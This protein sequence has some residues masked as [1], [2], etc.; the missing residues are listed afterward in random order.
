MI[1][2]KS[3]DRMFYVALTKFVNEVLKEILSYSKAEKPVGKT[4]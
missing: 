4:H 1:T 3:E 2:I